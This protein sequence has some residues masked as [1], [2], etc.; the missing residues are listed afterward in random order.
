MLITLLRHATAEDHSLNIADAERA[1][2]K[3]GENQVLRVAAFC[4]NNDLKPDALYCS[5][6]RRTRQ[7]A[8]ML[9]GALPDCPS[10]E[11]VDWLKAGTAPQLM[12]AELGR[13]HEKGYADIWLVGHEPDFSS[14]VARTI[15][16][17]G[18]CIDLKKASL[19]RLELDFSDQMYAQLLWSIP[20]SLMPAK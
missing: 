13:L 3:K 5:P 14:L 4:K 9:Q 20:C 19:T 18:D 15:N 7:T 10:A 17:S 8:E 11:T 6:L 12:L 2:I 1:L 16:A